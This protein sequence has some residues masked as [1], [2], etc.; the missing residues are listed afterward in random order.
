L[1]GLKPLQ[2]FVVPSLQGDECPVRNNKITQQRN[3]KTMNQRT[4]QIFIIAGIA[5][6]LLLAYNIMFGAVSIPLKEVFNIIFN[7][8]GGDV[9]PA[10]QHIILQS[11]LPQALTAVFAGAAL[12]VSGLLLQTVFRNPLAGPSILGVSD[13]ANLGVAIV[14]LLGGGTLS[15]SSHFSLTG[16]LSLITGALA[17]A[18]LI[19]AVILRFSAKISNAVMLLIVGMMTG[20]LASSVIAILNYFA[21]ADRVRAFVIWGLG[22]F[23]AVTAEKLPWFVIFAA[24]GII[25]AVM[26]VKPLN[27][28]LLGDNAAK[29]LGVNVKRARLVIILTTGVLTAVVTAFCGPVSFIGLA[30]PHIARMALNTSNHTVL[31]PATILAGACVA[32]LCNAMTTLPGADAI[33]PLNAITPVIGA[34]VIIYIIVNKRNIQ[35]FGQ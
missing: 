13:G 15:I 16:S 17:G 29:S 18:F 12:A 21:A 20:F 22:D 27:A 31:L 19:L 9:N 7:G 5:L 4:K 24:A 25:V 35:F 14:M 2:G 10:W 11:R 34:P 30:V 3:N 33:L 23:T 6:P 1:Q 8:N 28:L 26:L 32:L